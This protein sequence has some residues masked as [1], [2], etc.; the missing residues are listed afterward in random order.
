MESKLS[1]II[2]CF[3]A[4]EKNATFSQCSLAEDKACSSFGECL[5][6][7]ITTSP[8]C[9]GMHEGAQWKLYIFFAR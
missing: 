8:M 1:D 9:H 4:E 7:H 6:G 2:L 5:L 3:P